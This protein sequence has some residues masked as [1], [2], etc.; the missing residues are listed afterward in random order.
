MGTR[1]LTMVVM[2]GQIKIAQ[3][4]QWDGQPS[5]QGLTALSFLKSVNFDLFK[6]KLLNLNFIDFKNLTK[7]EEEEI[8]SNTNNKY[9]HL[10]RDHG[11]NILNLIYEGDINDLID[12]SS[13][14]NESLFCEWGYVIDFDTNVFEIFQ[15]FNKKKITKGRFISNKD[16][17]EYEPII[18]IK[19]YKLDDLP[20]VEKFLDDCKG[21]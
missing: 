17:G 5:G 16:E 7:E 19:S 2:D 3:Y 10:S 11:A 6:E 15:G 18:L 20:D 13:F 14:A 9:D 12:N 8:D 4:G 21:D 1:N